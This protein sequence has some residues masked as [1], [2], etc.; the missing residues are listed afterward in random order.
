MKKSSLPF[1]ETFKNFL[2]LK[3]YFFR[4]RWPLVFGLMSL[5]AVDFLQLLIPLVIKSAIDLLTIKTA[6]AHVL[7][8]HGLTILGIALMIAVFRYIWRHLIL[9]HSRKVEEGLRNQLYSHLQT[10]SLSFFQ[11][12]RT[13]DLMARAINDINGIRMATGMGLVAL[14]DG[15]VLGMA[16]IGFMMSIN[17]KLTLIS[18]IPAPIIVI[19]T[20]I[21]TRRMSSGFETVQKTFSELTERVREAFSGIRVIKSYNRENWEY[22]KVEHVGRKYISENMRLAKTLAFFFPMMA[23][24]TNTGLAIVIWFG[25]RLTIMGNIT[26]GDFVAFTAYLNL[27]TW[28]M[29]AMGWVTTLI[30][31]G[32]ASMRR[33]NNILE[34]VPEIKDSPQLRDVARITGRIEINGLKIR[35]SGQTEP[36]LKDIH[37]KIDAGETVAVVGR[38]GSGKT[39]LLHTIPRLLDISPATLF[40]DGRDIR[41]IPLK[42]LRKNI[43]FVTQDVFIFSDTV[44]NNVLFGRS[45][46]SQTEL[47]TA[48]RAADILEDIESLEKGLDTI[49][50]ERGIT[51]S[52]GQRQRLT[53]ARALIADPSILIMDDALSMVDTRTEQRILNQVFQLRRNKTSLIVSHRISTI[54][55][56]ERI[57]VLD[58]GEL[59]EEG[60][61][62][63]LMKRKGIYAVLYEKQLISNEL[64]TR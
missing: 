22:K 48:L 11:R 51:L 35:Y 15:A 53:I 59:V 34:E 8:K 44:R 16:A 24:F 46:V 42:T 1:T 45:N 27:L 17:V 9:G 63:T 30:Q 56:A 20:R 10:L 55:R 32:S 23:I 19:F 61:H 49:L 2:P 40:I 29:I 52:G 21:L 37:F 4:N 58:R 47:Y 14:T 60:T 62:E 38:V 31:R 7:F 39:T 50:G 64:E 36:A 33:I 41:Q 54:S 25:G 26:I 57:V 13:G 18:L 6:T 12:T 5:L 3:Q 28:P 43:G